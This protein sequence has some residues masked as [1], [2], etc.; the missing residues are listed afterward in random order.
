MIVR[1]LPRLVIYKIDK[2]QECH[3]TTTETTTVPVVVDVVALSFNDRS[4]FQM[5]PL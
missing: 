4:S 3:C 1:S 5:L 2:S